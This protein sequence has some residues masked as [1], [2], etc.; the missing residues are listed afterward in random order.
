MQKAKKSAPDFTT[1]ELTQALR[2]IDSIIH[3][4]EKAKEKFP[5]GNAH[6][7][8]LHNRLGAMYLSKELILE[9]LAEKARANPP[10]AQAGEQDECQLLSYL[11]ALHTTPLG[12]QRIQKNMGLDL[13]DVVGW[14]R[15]QALA[16]DARISRRGKNWYITTPGCEITVNAHSYTVITAHKKA[17]V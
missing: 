15:A 10:P 1:E 2:A 6:H 11:G 8:L 3:K 4:C 14:C 5:Q 13:V 7:S 12:A 16:P 9:K 17:S